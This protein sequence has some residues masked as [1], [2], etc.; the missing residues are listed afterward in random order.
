MK[1]AYEEAVQARRIAEEEVQAKEAEI[2]AIR[3]RLDRA[4]VL[5]NVVLGY[6]ER[7]AANCSGSWRAEIVKI[8]AFVDGKDGR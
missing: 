7:F 2:V 8:R 1:R 5:L 4:L 3:A 6:W